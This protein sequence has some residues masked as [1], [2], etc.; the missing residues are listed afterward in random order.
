MLDTLIRQLEKLRDDGTELVGGT[1]VYKKDDEIKFIIID[2]AR[3]TVNH[4]SKI[5]FK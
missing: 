3:K 1:L 4:W 5:N 2:P